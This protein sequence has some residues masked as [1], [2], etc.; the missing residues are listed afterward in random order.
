MAKIVKKIKIKIKKSG[1]LVVKNVEKKFRVALT[2]METR[3]FKAKVLIQKMSITK[4]APIDSGDS[5]SITE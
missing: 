3:N 4:L 2:N 5:T 1:K